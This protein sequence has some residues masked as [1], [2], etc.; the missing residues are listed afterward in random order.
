MLELIPRDRHDP[1]WCETTLMQDV[2]HVEEGA[3]AGYQTLGATCIQ[4]D[5]KRQ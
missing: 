3:E 2:N 5:T 1:G 4:N